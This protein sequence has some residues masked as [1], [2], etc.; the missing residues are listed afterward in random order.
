MCFNFSFRSLSFSNYE[1]R[2]ARAIQ[3]RNALATIVVDGS[4]QQCS[5]PTQKLIE[6]SFYSGKK[7]N[8][9]SHY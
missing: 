5:V 7:N 8:I 9:Q 4:E 1:E 6:Q 2:Y 3:F